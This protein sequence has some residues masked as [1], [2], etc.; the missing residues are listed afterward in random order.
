MIIFQ[1]KLRINRFYYIQRNNYKNQ[2][3]INFDYRQ[4]DF[5]SFSKVSIYFLLIAF[6][7]YFNVYPE[8]MKYQGIFRTCADVV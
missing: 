3:L 4:P 8:S 6:D 2:I 1:K 5:R 7:D